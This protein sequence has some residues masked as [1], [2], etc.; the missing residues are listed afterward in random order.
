VKR[1]L[2][3]CPHNAAKSVL[4]AAYFRQE[5]ARRGLNWMADSAGTEP[6]AEVAPAVK[7]LL[8]SAGLPPAP[9][10]RLVKAEEIRAASLVIAMGCD[11][12]S[13]PAANDA[14]ERWDDLPAVSADPDRA[15]GLIRDRIRQLVAALQEA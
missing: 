10:P 12:A 14:T 6:E 7:G 11:P 8:Q 15:A 3:L 13:L 4:A 1:V 2:F 9:L 5:A